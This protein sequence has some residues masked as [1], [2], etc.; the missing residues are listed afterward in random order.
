MDSI[1][2]AF[3]LAETYRDFHALS[4][5]SHH[6]S[7]DKGIATSDR[8]RGYIDRFRGEFTSQLYRWYI[9]QGRQLYLI[10]TRDLLMTTGK[11]KSLFDQEAD[12]DYLDTF[13]SQNPQ[14]RLSWIHDLG[15]Q[16]YQHAASAL[17]VEA[18]VEYNREARH[19]S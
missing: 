13:F 1:D 19:V 15:K 8:I 2:Y 14:P 5:L 9:E 6:T 3:K 12:S 17:L 16:D 4:E 11:L 10:I 18:Q 7:A